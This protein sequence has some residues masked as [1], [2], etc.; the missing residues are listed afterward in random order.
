MKAVYAALVLALSTT[1]APIAAAQAGDDWPTYGHDKGGMRFS[2]LA[3]ITPDNVSTLKPA[4]TYHMRPADFVMAPAAPPPA[5]V[6]TGNVAG[7][8]GQA[9]A[10]NGGIPGRGANARFLQSEATP[11]IVD[12][13]M[14]LTSPYRKIVALNATTG[15][16]VWTHDSLGSLRGVE[17]WAGDRS[18]PAAIIYHGEG[19]LVSLNAKTGK[20][21]VK[22]GVNGVLAA[23]RAAPGTGGPGGGVPTAPPIIFKNIIISQSANPNKDGREGDIRAFDVVTGKQLWRFDTIPRE[24]QF[25]YD[26]WAPGSTIGRTSVQAWGGMALDD[27]RGIVYIPIDAPTWDRYGGDRKGDNLFST[28]M[29]AL[30]ATTGARVWHFQIVHHDIWDFDAG[31]P[32]AL[33]DI[34]QDGKTVPGIGIISKSGLLFLLDRTNGKPIYGVEERPVPQ[35]DVPGEFT[36]PTQPFPVKPPP[37]VRMTMSKEEIAD[38]TPELNKFCTDLVAQEN[39]GMGGPFLPP[40]WLRPTVNFPGTQGSANWGGMSF[41]PELG[42]VFVN[43]HDLGQMTGIG[44]KGSPRKSID[45]SGAGVGNTPNIPYDMAGQLGRFKEP[46][47]NMMCQDPPWGSLTAVNVNTGDIAWKVTLGVTDALPPEKQL[48][49]RP[50]SGGTIATAGGLVFVAATDDGRFRAFEAKT[51]KM[52]W[53]TMLPAVSHSVPSTYRGKDGKQYVAIVATGGG[54]LRAPAQS[55]S[56][57]AYALP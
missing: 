23:P 53:E 31:S 47:S 44:P 34:K 3:Q 1:A 17:Y 15:K 54:F 5:N 52:V 18:N 25:G 10:V 41:N 27:Q 4:W 39:V 43:T 26:T 8:A 28:S 24:G 19:G 13:L 32:P 51:G 20:P 40:G 21:N 35:S 49:G 46:V 6:V 48:T 12:G 42:Y 55:D 14:Y 9:A 38:V 36:S 30:N 50:N 33:F 22:F 11:L 56:V 57:I 37:F 45:T 7:V 2:P 29:I 16:E